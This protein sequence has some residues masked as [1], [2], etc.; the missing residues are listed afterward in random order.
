MIPLLHPQTI[1]QVKQR[2]D[3]AD[4][5]SDRVVLKKAGKDLAG[6]CPFH[7]DKSPSFTVSPSKGFYHCFACGASGDAIKFLM[8]LDKRSFSDV[9]VDLARRY[10]VPVET[11]EPEKRQEIQRQQSDRDQLYEILALAARFF[12]HALHQP[13]GARALDYLREVRGLNEATIEQFQL[14]YSPAGWDTLLAYLT[15]QKRYPIEQVERAG[16][17]VPRKAG[18]YYDRFRDRL[19][20]PI[21]DPQ[22]RVIGFG[23]RALGSDEPKYLNSPET[24]LFDKGKTLFG[25]DLAR[26]AI[27]KQDAAIVVEGY[28]DVIAL[29]AVGIGQAVAALGTAL[30][31]AQI[32]LLSRYTES[33]RIILNFDGDRAG[34]KA[35]ERAIGEVAALAYQG[36]IQ[37]RVLNLPGGKDADE[38]L[39][40]HRV[41]DYQ[42]L[43]DHAPLWLDWQIEQA[44]APRD[45]RQADQFQAAL[46]EV[47][48]LL[49]QLPSP[50]LRSHYV[51]HCAERLGQQDARYTAQLEQDLQTQVGGQRRRDR[52]QRRQRATGTTPREAAEGQILQI[53]L[54][55]PDCRLALQ[56]LIEERE[57]EFALSPHRFV[58]RHI[59]EWVAA[60]RARGQDVESLDLVGELRGLMEASGE[61]LAAIARLLHLDEL[62]QEDLQRPG[63]VMRSALASLETLSCQQRCHYL[64][65]TWLEHWLEYHLA[66]RD[67]MVAIDQGAGGCVSLAVLETRVDYAHTAM[68]CY[69]GLYY[70]ERRYLEQLGR[71]RLTSFDDLFHPAAIGRLAG[72]LVGEG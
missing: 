19:M 5:V 17:I 66:E 23:G 67:L 43:I 55:V 34:Q 45:L 29:H 9:V 31:S 25:L 61:E 27:A 40:A 38:F 12:Q 35:T 70:Q 41:A 26:T 28:F 2:A 63:L 37:L 56:A 21:C 7:D 49:G 10:Q 57:I 44:I 46:G 11:V 53:F 62:A 42:A 6:L 60:A 24:E 32:K 36:E 30:S 8:E 71:Q 13:S 39:K 20:I 14:G 50:A 4:V 1:E 69:H 47:V 18:G 72:A 22:G 68:S 64:Q 3:I 54:H 59:S 33:K 51:R 65:I 58:W 16:L 15:E 52:A 48:E